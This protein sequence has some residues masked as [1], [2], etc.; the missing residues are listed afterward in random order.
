[1]A[2]VRGCRTSDACARAHAARPAVSGRGDGANLVAVTKNACCTAAGAGNFTANTNLDL[3]DVQARAGFSRRKPDADR[4][5]EPRLNI[6]RDRMLPY[7]VLPSTICPEN[8]IDADFR[9][10]SARQGYLCVH[11]DDLPRGS[12]SRPLRSSRLHLVD[13]KE[14][15]MPRFIDWKRAPIWRMTS[16]LADSCASRTTRIREYCGSAGFFTSY[17][18]SRAAA[19][20]VVFAGVARSA[21]RTILHWDCQLHFETVHLL[22]VDAYFGPSCGR[23]VV[24]DGEPAHYL[25]DL[26]CC[27][28]A[29]IAAH[30]AGG[31][32]ER[33]RRWSN[34]RV[35]CGSA[36]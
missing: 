10:A 35:N 8:A 17:G 16:R 32:S 6:A 25:P 28:A 34:W 9:A 1:M 30:P 31:M 26:S 36:R 27:R 24:T 19:R 12:I 11:S 21:G 23:S 29:R 33:G 5:G 7:R 14:T 20:G 22:R 15:A 2:V 4:R 18:A 3:V 13:H